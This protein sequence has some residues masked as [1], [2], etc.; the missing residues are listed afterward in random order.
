MSDQPKWQQEFDSIVSSIDM[1]HF[2][3]IVEPIRVWELRR[4]ILGLNEAAMWLGTIDLDTEAGDEYV[5]CLDD[6]KA[7]LIREVIDLTGFLAN[8]MS[9]GYECDC[10]DD[11][12]HDFEDED[13]D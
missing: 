1:D 9:G 10:E 7:V 4:A 13:E 2:A 12:C 8:S 11:E 3:D 5:S 6:E